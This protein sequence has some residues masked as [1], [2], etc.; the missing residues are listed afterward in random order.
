MCFLFFI[1]SCE[2]AFAHSS[3]PVSVDVDS[4]SVSFAGDGVFPLME[5]KPNQL[6][7][8]FEKQLSSS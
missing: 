4:S 6:V 5:K 3:D 7:A 1:S 8:S 2:S